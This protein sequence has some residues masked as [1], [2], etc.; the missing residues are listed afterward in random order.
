MMLMTR[1]SRE[2]TRCFLV[3][4]SLLFRTRP[5]NPRELICSRRSWCTHSR[6]WH[7]REGNFYLATAHLH[8]FLATG[9][10]VLSFVRFLFSFYLTPSFLVCLVTK[11]QEKY[12][13]WEILSWACSMIQGET[14]SISLPIDSL[15]KKYKKQLCVRQESTRACLI[16]TETAD[17]TKFPDT[18]NFLV[19]NQGCWLT[20]LGARQS[21]LFLARASHLPTAILAALRGQAIFMVCHAGPH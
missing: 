19:S 15:K 3:G 11:P 16:K 13:I 21:K 7:W 5:E 2:V 4:I 1:T 18:C 8:A 14:F 17:V 9:P 6:A 20:P 12:A 10:V